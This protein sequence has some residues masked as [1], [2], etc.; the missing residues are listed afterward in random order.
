MSALA[1]TEGSNTL[2]RSAICRFRFAAGFG[3]AAFVRF[4]FE[5]S[6]AAVNEVLTFRVGKSRRYPVTQ[7]TTGVSAFNWSVEV[8]C[9][10]TVPLLALVIL[11]ACNAEV[12]GPK[13]EVTPPEI[14]IRPAIASA[15][16]FCPPGQAKKGNCAG[17][18]FCPPGQAK[19][20][21]C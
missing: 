1:V 2:R 20:S 7:A 21:N 10:I 17:T 14:V 9:R 5:F 16:D 19:K 13:A 12:K 8:M 4:L 18:R 15:A 3:G 6:V 11:S